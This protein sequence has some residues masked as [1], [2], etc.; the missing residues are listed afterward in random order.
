MEVNPEHDIVPRL[1]EGLCVSIVNNLLI[2]S[3]VGWVICWTRNL[4]VPLPTQEFKWAPVNF[5][6]EFPSM[7]QRPVEED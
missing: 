4:T 3:Y 1:E 7:D 2:Q 6:R 5:V